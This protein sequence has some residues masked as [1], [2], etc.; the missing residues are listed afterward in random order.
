[1]SSESNVKKENPMR[2]MPVR[3]IH[4]VRFKKWKW[5]IITISCIWILS[6]S[7]VFARSLENFSLTATEEDLG[8]INSIIEALYQS[9]TFSEGKEPNLERLR[10]LFHPKA[11]FI[12]VTP[13]GVDEMDLSSFISSFGDRVKSG[14]LKSFHESEISRKMEHHGSIAQV[15]STYQKGMNTENPEEYGRGI[16]SIQLYYDGQRWWIVSITWEDEQPSNPLPRKYL[17]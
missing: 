9:I 12:R 16:N 2:F 4:T 13:Q 3:Q 1:M 14:Q 10:S 8:S 7:L 11:P 15:F 6:S 17:R 5:F